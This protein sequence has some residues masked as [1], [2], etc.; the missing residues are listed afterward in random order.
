ML[1]LAGAMITSAQDARHVV[2]KIQTLCATGKAD[3]ALRLVAKFPGLPAQIEDLQKEST[4]RTLDAIASGEVAINVIA[5]KTDGDCAVVFAKMEKR[6]QVSEDFD[7]IYCIKQAGEWKAAP[8]FSDWKTAA[9]VMNKKET[10]EKLH[11][12]FMAEKARAKE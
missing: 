6:G 2:E 9:Q 3:E 4:K 1:I 12:W 7:P 10:F 8:K 5:E 11:V